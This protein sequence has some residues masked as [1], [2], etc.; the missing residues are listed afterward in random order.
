MPRVSVVIASYNHE[1]YVRP[2]IESVLAQSFQDFEILVSDDGS[3]DRTVAEVQAMSDSR[4]SLVALPCNIGG[5]AALNAT[6]LRANGDLIA[7]LNSDDMFLPEKLARQVRHLDENPGVAAVFTLPL[8][9]G[10]D[11]RPHPNPSRAMVALANEK[12]RP[13]HGWLRRFFRKGNGLCHPSVLIRRRCYEE[14]G[15]YN[16]ALAQVPD[17]EMWVR[18]LRTEDIHLIE[19]PLVG[20]RIRDSQMN[21]SALRPEVIL[22]NNWECLRILERY[23]ELDDALL[24]LTF[25]EIA[26]RIGTVP[27][28]LLMA[29]MAVR[30]G[31][32]PHLLFALET[33]YKVA[34]SGRDPVLCRALIATTGSHDPFGLLTPPSAHGTPI[35]TAAADPSHI[36]ARED[37]TPPDRKKL[38]LGCG[39]NILRGWVN[40]DIEGPE[41]VLRWDLTRPLPFATGTADFIFNEHF[42]EHIT[43]PEAS[44][45]LSEC[46]RLLASRGVLRI[47]TPSLRKL[48]DEYLNHRTIEWVD[49]GWQPATPCQMLNESMRLWG[50]QFLYDVEELTAL[51]REVGFSDV[52]SVGWRQSRH[53]A[54]RDLE[55]RPFHNEIILEATK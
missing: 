30:H 26:D 6:I 15:L 21:A 48:I 24:G 4:I 51:L 25:P 52:V 41:E 1:K 49:V 20:F 31:G 17:L 3:S 9:I 19:E 29:E 22:R 10:E 53:G 36:V 40:I 12:N 28:P 33:M 47:S 8:C 44:A 34:A 43:R 42:I 2:A 32:P 37:A 50:H 35:R 38:H 11:G 39:T 18:L 14:V 23:L 27:T 46:H 5:S 7:V 16:P 54:L 55:C 13:R 45:L